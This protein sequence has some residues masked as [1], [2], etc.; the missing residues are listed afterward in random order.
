VPELWAVL[1]DV[2]GEVVVLEITAPL[3]LVTVVVTAPSAAVVTVVVSPD[4]EVVVAVVVD[5]TP[6]TA[7]DRLEAE[8]VLLVLAGAEPELAAEFNA[9]SA[10]EI[11]L[12]PL[13]DIA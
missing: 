11:P 12:I 6:E 8:D 3:E 10:L 7:E 13:M 2:V 4:E 9:A 5:D 1:C